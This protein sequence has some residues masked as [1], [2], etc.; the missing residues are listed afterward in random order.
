MRSANAHRQRR[1]H[2]HLGW[3]SKHTERR[4]TGAGQMRHSLCSNQITIQV[5]LINE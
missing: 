1:G 5:E 2:R 3:L 4:M